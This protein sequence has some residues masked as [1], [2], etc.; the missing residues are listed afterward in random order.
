MQLFLLMT[1]TQVVGLLKK[2]EINIFPED[3]LLLFNLFH[4]QK[5]LRNTKNWFP[6]C[7][8]GIE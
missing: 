5:A 3:I 2:K 6:I 8:P 4:T 1:L 7:L